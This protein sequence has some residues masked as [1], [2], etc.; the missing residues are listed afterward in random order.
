MENWDGEEW[1]PI[2]GGTGKAGFWLETCPQ[3]P[4][5]LL[6]ANA[7]SSRSVKNQWVPGAAMGLTPAGLVSTEHCSINQSFWLHESQTSSSYIMGKLHFPKKSIFLLFPSVSQWNLTPWSSVLTW[8]L[9]QVLWKPPCESCHE[10]Q[11]LK[12]WRRSPGECLV[13]GE[14]PKSLLVSSPQNP[15]LRYCIQASFILMKV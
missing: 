12:Y 13:W 8:H 1:I 7:N 10:P 5:W 4:P 6:L 3:A 11:R 15:W 14:H 9:K 2:R